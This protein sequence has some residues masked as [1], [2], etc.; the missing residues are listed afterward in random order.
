VSL[1]DGL[2]EEL[3]FIGADVR[4]NF[5]HLLSWDKFD[6][7]AAVVEELEHELTTL[8]LPLG[9]VEVITAAVVDAARAVHAHVSDAAAE[10]SK[11]T[12]EEIADQIAALQAQLDPSPQDPDDGTAGA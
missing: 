7:A 10:A 4:E 11:L 3:G 2:R 9:P 5:G 6:R 12:Q 1:L 8:G